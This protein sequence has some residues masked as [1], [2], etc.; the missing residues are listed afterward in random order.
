MSNRIKF[1]LDEQIKSVIARELRRRRI[2]VATNVEARLRTKTDLVVMG[3]NIDTIS[4]VD[5]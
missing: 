4:K 2:D 5:S 3:V 1:H